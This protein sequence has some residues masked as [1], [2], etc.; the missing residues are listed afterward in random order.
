MTYRATITVSKEAIRHNC[1]E[2]K[3]QL[4]KNTILSAVI[5][6]NAYGIGGQKIAPILY[7]EGIKDF[8]VANLVEAL[9]IKKCLKKKDVNIF[10]LY[11]MNIGNYKQIIKNKFI[12]VLNSVNTIEFWHEKAKNKPCIINID[13]G[14]CRLGINREEVN[15]LA[16]EGIFEDMKI[17]Y[18]M[19]HFSSGNI[20]DNTACER[21]YKEFLKIAK[22]FPKGTKLSLA[23]SGGIFRNKRYHLDM[24]R[25]GRTLYGLSPL[26]Y[27]KTNLVNSLSLKARVLQIKDVKKDE[28]VGY[29]GTYKMKKD[30]KLAIINVGYADSLLRNH[31]NK[32]CFYFKG[33]KLPIVGLISMDVSTVDISNLDGIK[34]EEDDWVEII[35]EHQTVDELGASASTNGCEILTSL[36]VR[37]AW[38][39][40]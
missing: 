24:V 27:K 15:Q 3:K 12:P 20:E 2:I 34:I 40:K 33:Q 35:G 8:F 26:I 30:G 37:Y 5:K 29:M 23:N 6:A 32:G 19:A 38:I 14:I 10:I 18:V 39:F 11:D 25:A 13:S 28:P 21:E 17:S 31:S 16:K 9:K 22:L 1:S 4:S 36:S 7:Q